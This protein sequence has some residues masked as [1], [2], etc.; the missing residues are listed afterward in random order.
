[1]RFTIVRNLS[2][3]ALSKSVQ[4]LRNRIKKRIGFGSHDWKGKWRF[5]KS[6]SSKTDFRKLGQSHHG[7]V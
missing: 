2:E 1:M 6:K 4:A 3:M 7:E 5:N